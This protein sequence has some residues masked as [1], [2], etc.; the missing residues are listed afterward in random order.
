MDFV[1]DQYFPIIDELEGELEKLEDE[2]FDASPRRRDNPEEI[3][4]LKREML[5]VKRAIAPLIDVCNRLV[6]FDRMLIRPETRL[7][8]RDVYDHVVRINETL[9]SMRE[10][11]TGA[12]ES[13]LALIGIRQNE[14]MQRLASYA[15]LIAVPTLIAGIYGMNFKTMP[16]LDWWLGYPMSIGLMVGVCGYLF[17]RFR[18]SGW[19]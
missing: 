19:L 3:Y 15:A 5:S 11:L 7:Y 10:L 1:V 4:R 8:F 12:L 13:N 17:Y 2:I 16:E 9:D 18:K 6:R 14:T